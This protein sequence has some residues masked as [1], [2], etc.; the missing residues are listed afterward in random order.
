VGNPTFSIGAIV[1]EALGNLFTRAVSAPFRALANLFG[2]GED[3]GEALS[4][5]EFEPGRD[6]L[7]PEAEEKLARM[8][9]ALKQRPQLKLVV[10]G[11][12]DP[13][14]DE[15]AL[16][17]KAARRDLAQALGEALKEDEDPGPIAYGNAKTQRELEQLLRTRAGGD[18]VQDFERQY[19]TKTG[20]AVD[21]VN[22]ALALVGRASPDRAFYAAVFERLTER[23]PLPDSAAPLLAARRAQ[24]IVDYL[25]KSA[26]VAPERV[27]AGE[28]RTVNASEESVS[29]RLALDSIDGAP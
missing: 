25:M 8:A 1:R 12:Y 28:I 16:R 22:P 15:Q 21:R 10:R 23:T 3:E 17:V 7:R 9:Q 2:G 20:K 29:A 26:G 6:A 14:R 27:R 13:K 19:E 4:R 24:A 5:I 18:A 11:P